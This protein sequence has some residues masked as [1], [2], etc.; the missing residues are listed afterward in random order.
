MEYRS[1]IITL[2]I[3]IC[4]RMLPCFPNYFFKSG[5]PCFRHLLFPVPSLL[6]KMGTGVIQL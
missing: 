6:G 3:N 5:L 1:N 4:K 2:K